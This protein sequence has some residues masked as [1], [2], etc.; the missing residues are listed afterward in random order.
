MKYLRERLQ[1]RGATTLSNEELLLIILQTRPTGDNI[2]DLVHSLLV[3]SGGLHGLLRAEYGELDK[4]YQLGRAKAAQLQAVLELAKR[5]MAPSYEQKYRIKYAQDAANLVMAEMQHLDH[6]EIRVLVLDTK[7][8]VV[9]NLLLYQGTVS[10]SV[11]RVAELLRP[12]VVR[13]CPSILLCHNHPSG[14]TDP[15]AEDIAVTRQCLEGAKV[16]D[17]ELLDHLIIGDHGFLSLKEYMRW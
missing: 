1:H 16:L 7:N 15:S 8:Q 12:A 9:A 2:G 6:E 11:L 13:K 3:R 4:D 17:I 10:S 5:L 14:L